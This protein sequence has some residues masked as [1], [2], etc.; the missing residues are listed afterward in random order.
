[1]SLVAHALALA[2]TM[3]PNDLVFSKQAGI[4]LLD[5]IDIF[6]LCEDVLGNS[7]IYDR[8][9]GMAS[10]PSPE[11]RPVLDAYYDR[12]RAEIIRDTPDRQQRI[13]AV[14]RTTCAAGMLLATDQFI[15]TLGAD[16]TAR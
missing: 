9:A 2:L 6:A 8:F 11:L 1:M 14:D 13:Q 16:A 10:T 3:G 7:E 5:A 12:K 15:E 4:K